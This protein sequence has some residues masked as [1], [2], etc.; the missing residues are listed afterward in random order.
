MKAYKEIPSRDKNIPQKTPTDWLLGWA[1]IFAKHQMQEKGQS[2]TLS[3]A[4]RSPTGL[5]KALNTLPYWFPIT[6]LILNWPRF[7][8]PASIKIELKSCPAQGGFHLALTSMILHLTIQASLQSSDTLFS[9]V[10]KLR[11]MPRRRIGT[12]VHPKMHL[13]SSSCPQKSGHSSKAI[14]TK[15]KGGIP[16]TTE[17]CLQTK[18]QKVKINMSTTPLGGTQSI[19]TSLTTYCQKL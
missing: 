6:T 1:T 18:H 11:W 13:K 9:S 8:Q 3:I 5:E 14:S 2:K 19:P 4:I 16:P 7:S 12:K 17:L 10:Q 15:S